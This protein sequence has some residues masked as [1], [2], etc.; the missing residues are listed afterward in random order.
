[1][2]INKTELYKDFENIENKKDI[3]NLA[4]TSCN[5]LDSKENIEKNTGFFLLLIILILFIIVFIIFCI[6]GYNLLEDKMDE[7]IYKK[8][9]KQK[10]IERKKSKTIKSIIN[11]RPNNEN[12]NNK[13]KSLNIGTI[14]S[15]NIH[16]ALYNH[17]DEFIF[18][19]LAETEKEKLS[20][21]EKYYISF[22][23]SDK[24]GY[25]IKAGG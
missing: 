24:Y 25:N 7:I 2:T 18:Y 12:K 14:K 1:M 21:M 6:K 9:E 19:I 10:K 11:E 13:R 17:W 22:Y 15:T 16:K 4:I 5:V 8:F 3:A 23:E 20:E